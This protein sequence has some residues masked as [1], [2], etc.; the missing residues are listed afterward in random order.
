MKLA[1]AILTGAAALWSAA[2]IAQP[3][4]DPRIWNLG[5]H[6]GKVFLSFAQPETDDVMV[7]F[8]CN[9]GAGTVD[10][11]IAA[12]SEKLKPGETAD[13][14]LSAGAVSAQFRGGAS[15]NLMD[16]V[17]SLSAVA[18]VND[19]FFAGLAAAKAKDIFAIAAK[20]D[21]QK[22]SL[23]SLGGKGKSFAAKCKPGG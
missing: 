2:A 5:E 12:A 18:G 6:E 9:L 21:T 15:V 3:A 4:D 22:A 16:G 10:I 23:K 19:P 7:N 20:G 13:F 8:Q 14:T 1:P 11:F 17:P